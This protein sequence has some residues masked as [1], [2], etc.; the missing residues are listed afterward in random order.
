MNPLTTVLATCLFTSLAS[1]SIACG[2]ESFE[3]FVTNYCIKC[4]GPDHQESELR[5]DK[6]SRDFQAGGE[7]H[8]WAELIE[9]V[10]SGEMPPAD[11]PQPT[12]DEIA[13][14]V[15]ILDSLINE[16][17]AARMA[18]RPP[19]VHYR[20]S[21]KEYQNTV[22]DLLG[23]RYDPTQPGEL[24]EDTL[25]HGYERIG[26]ELSL[27]ASHMD[28]YYRAA[29][30]VLDRAFPATPKE[31]RKVRKTAG[32]LR[33][34]D[35][36][37]A[38]QESLDRFGIKRPLRCL[39]Y[40]GNYRH[41]FSS[42]WLGKAGPEHSGFYKLRFKASGIR[43]PGG[44]PTHLS[45]GTSA[46]S[47]RDA[48]NGLI[49][50]DI[51]APEDSPEVYESQVVLEMPTSLHF[52]VVATDALKGIHFLRLLDGGSYIFTHSS[53]NLLTPQAAPQLFDDK[54]SGLYS[55]VI[56]DWVEWEGPLE[57]EAEKFRRTGV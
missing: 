39:I 38:I 53:E 54:G 47:E 49:E 8:R 48:V 19:V 14:F 25:W 16:G 41:A 35:G 55:M 30:L 6:L 36:E 13:K 1:G 21:R 15:S 9:R 43:P 34:G 28:R 33:Y 26:S 18:A 4:H 50:M 12:Q 7:A 23:V 51:T 17:R 52:N 32:E 57:T 20:L 31:A 3:T 2:D 24:N 22:Y 11:E 37:K 5:I 56:L 29:E 27:S 40:P 42:H 46:G 10:N 45:I 44:Q